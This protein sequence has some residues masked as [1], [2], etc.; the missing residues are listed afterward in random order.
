[1][2]A[3]LSFKEVHSVGIFK[4]VSY[5]NLACFILLRSWG[6]FSSR[7]VSAGSVFLGY[8]ILH[9]AMFSLPRS[10]LSGPL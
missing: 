6:N 5:S 2:A 1:M 7:K 9:T 3:F 8:G 10:F 4:G